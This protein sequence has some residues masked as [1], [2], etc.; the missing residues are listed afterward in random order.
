[1]TEILIISASIISGVIT[2]ILAV[3]F[4]KI[5]ITI[6]SGIFIFVFGICLRIK[7]RNIKNKIFDN[8]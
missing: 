4:F 5:I 3:N 7:L 6:S 2:K 1:M 8:N